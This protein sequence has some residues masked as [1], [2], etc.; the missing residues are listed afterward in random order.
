MASEWLYRMNVVT[1]DLQLGNALAGAMGFGTEDHLTF[2]KGAKLRPIGS[3][4]TEPSAW[5]ASVPL[6]ATGYAIV[7][8]FRDGGYP[9][10]LLDK[11]I[12]A[13]QIDAARA[14]ITL[15]VG[16]RATLEGNGLAFIAANGLEILPES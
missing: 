13:E 10:A 14:V 1:T 6:K 15:E 9:Q 12:T 16:D 3:E 2:T 8:E 11:G 5:F 4:D 7:S